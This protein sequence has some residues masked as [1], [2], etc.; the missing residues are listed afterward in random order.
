[1]SFK[2]I[3]IITI[4]GGI[5][6]I[7]NNK[8]IIKVGI[9]G[10]NSSIVM[11][12]GINNETP[13]KHKIVPSIRA[14]VTK[15]NIGKVTGEAVDLHKKLYAKIGEE[16]FIIGEL[17][18]KSMNKGNRE[19]AKLSSEEKYEKVSEKNSDLHLVNWQLA[20]IACNLYTKYKDIGIKNQQGELEFDVMVSVGLPL[21]EARYKDK[22]K[23]YSKA[24]FGTH[25]I[26]FLHPDFKGLVVILNII[27]VDVCTEGE[28]S[29]Q[30]VICGKESNSLDFNSLANG[31]ISVVD[32]G[33]ND[34][35][36]VGVRFYEEYEDEDFDESVEVMT[37]IYPEVRPELSKGIPRGMAWVMHQVIEEVMQNHEIQ[38]PL[39][40]RDIE[41]SFR[42][43]Y[44]IE[45][46]KIDIRDIFNKYLT[47][48]VKTLVDD[49]DSTYSN[50][51]AKSMIVKI[52]LSGGGAKN[53]FLVGMF[54][55]GLKERGY[56]ISKISVLGDQVYRNAYGYYYSL[57]D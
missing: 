1:V 21:I 34:T 37:D 18:G 7:T 22:R 9:D 48:Y 49:F 42:T 8:Q 14:E 5:I 2:Y 30:S 35:N 31:I 36:I 10:G 20:T 15:N 45:P 24:F 32:I 28:A 26:Q 12:S 33:S 38:R 4:K 23:K 40:R 51:G 13:F 52:Y 3:T 44:K 6:L 54:T 57:I 46:E 19:N 47:D 53:K 41:L 25:K 50:V 55:D 16:E 56:D 43:D 39:V 17:A 29:F 11:F 27:S